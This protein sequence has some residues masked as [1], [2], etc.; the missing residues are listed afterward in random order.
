MAVVLEAPPGWT[1]GLQLE[2]VME[3]GGAEPVILRVLEAEVVDW[4]YLK[5]KEE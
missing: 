5:V 3:A 4:E 2:V 1:V